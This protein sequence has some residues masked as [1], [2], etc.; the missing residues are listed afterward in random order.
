MINLQN[1]LDDVK[2]YETVRQL[3]WSGGVALEATVSG[4]GGDACEEQGS[5]VGRKI[6]V[7][8]ASVKQAIIHGLIGPWVM[9]R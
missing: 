1:L 6:T 5:G 9:Q 2:C 7:K 8:P 3:R 4:A